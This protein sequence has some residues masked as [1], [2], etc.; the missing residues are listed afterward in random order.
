[1]ACRSFAASSALQ[2][3]GIL[4]INRIKPHTD[5][6]GALGSGLLKMSVIGLGKRKGAAAMHAAAMHHGYEHVIRSMARV[7]LSE[8][9]VAG[10]R[11]RFS[12]INGTTPRACSSLPREDIET[13]EDALLAEARALMP[14][15]PFDELDL[16]IVD[17]MGKNIS[18]AGMDPNIIGRSIHGYSSM[19]GRERTARAVHP[20]DFR[21]GSYARN[22]RQC[23]WHRLGRFRHQPAGPRRSTP[24]LLSSMRSPP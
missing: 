9:P 7:L 4:L 17:R 1:M 24:A 16:L 6:F 23:H 20:Q 8:A 5:F 3:D 12:K 13:A 11:R 18:G 2:S 21:A 19:L 14:L 22:T 15:L 10:R